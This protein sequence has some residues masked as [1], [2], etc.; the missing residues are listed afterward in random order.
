[1]PNLIPTT[2]QSALGMTAVQHNSQVMTPMWLAIP[3]TQPLVVQLNIAA[4]LS[5][6][7]SGPSGSNKY[8]LISPGLPTLPQKVIERIKAK[9]YVDF[10]EL[11]PARGL[12][13]SVPSHLEGQVVVIQA[14][15][16]AASWKLIPNFG[17]QYFA[18]YA[19]ICITN[20][21]SLANDLMAYFYS[22]AA[23]AKRYPWPTWVLYDQSFCEE[24]A[25][26]PDPIMGKR[27]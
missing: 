24:S 7:G 20:Q 23:M 25:W 5:Q 18:L 15:D 2:T 27:T 1:M 8:F 9:E 12:N 22:I 19:A 16:L 4:L 13:K 14:N 6:Q 21:P 11:P 17:S 26:M 10:N 3:Q